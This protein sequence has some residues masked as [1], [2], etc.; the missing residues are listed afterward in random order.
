MKA[1]GLKKQLISAVLVLVMAFSSLA[2]TTFAWFT[3]MVSSSGNMI[4]SGR[5]DAE[6]YYSDSL[7][8]PDWKNAKDSPVFTHDNWE[9]GYTDIKYIKVRI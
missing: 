9:P 7:A 3:D 4:Q 1:A 2:G 6:M 8:N 5:L